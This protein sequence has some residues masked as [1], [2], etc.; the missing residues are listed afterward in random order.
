MLSNLSLI[1]QQTSS[2]SEIQIEIICLKI[3]VIG[4]LSGL[5]AAWERLLLIRLTL[6][7]VFVILDVSLELF[8]SKAR[9]ENQMILGKN[10]KL[11]DAQA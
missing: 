2:K 10:K 3:Q 6:P 1:M 7:S 11:K 5:L 9:E 8:Q 4:V